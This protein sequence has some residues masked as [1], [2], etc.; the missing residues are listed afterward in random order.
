MFIGHRTP[1]G[2]VQGD[3]SD[4]RIVVSVALIVALAAIIACLMWVRHRIRQTTPEPA[5]LDNLPLPEV[6]RR[7]GI[8]SYLLESI[9]VITYRASLES[10]EHDGVSRTG[11]STDGGQRDDPLKGATIV[12]TQESD[13]ELPVKNLDASMQSIDMSLDKDASQAKQRKGSRQ[14]SKTCSVCTEEFVEGRNVRILPCRHIYH[15]RCIDPWLLDFAGT[16]PMWYVAL[17]YE[18]YTGGRIL[19]GFGISSRIALQDLVPPSTQPPRPPEPALLP[20]ETAPA[21]TLARLTRLTSP[22]RILRFY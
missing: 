5:P 3:A 10:N 19:T 1:G 4:S 13:G 12:R 17:I 16:C 20:V 8:N 22:R 11:D 21:P 18:L 9:P 2:P 7:K 15:R 6:Q 14:D